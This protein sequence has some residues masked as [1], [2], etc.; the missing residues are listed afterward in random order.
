MPPVKP[1]PPVKPRPPGPKEKIKEPLTKEKVTQA[2]E[3]ANEAT[4]QPVALAEGANDAL[5]EVNNA[6][7][8]NGLPPYV[9][10]PGLAQA[11]SQAAATRA[12]SLTEGHTANDFSYLPAG[13]TARAAGCAAW[14][15]SMGWGACATLDT[16]FTHAGAA[17]VIGRDGRRYMHAFYR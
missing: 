11:A 2:A 12:A 16:G 14:P 9:Y 13:A 8:Q 7:A 4:V 6:R 15:P 1:Q 3:E 10:D 5:V 17:Y